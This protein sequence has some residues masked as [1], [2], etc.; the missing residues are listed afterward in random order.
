[1]A[2]EEE[3]SRAEEDAFAEGDDLPPTWRRSV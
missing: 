3:L 2:T 1:L